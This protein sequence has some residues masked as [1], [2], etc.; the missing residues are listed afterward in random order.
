MTVEDRVDQ[1]LYRTTSVELFDGDFAAEGALLVGF[2]QETNV[3][4]P[5]GSM[6]PDVF[7]G[8]HQCRS[9]LIKLETVLNEWNYRAV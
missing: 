9:L 1:I 8:E 7:Y 5:R 6:L 3:G 4:G 2:P